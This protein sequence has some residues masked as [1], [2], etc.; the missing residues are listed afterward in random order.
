MPTLIN[1]IELS[2][3]ELKSIVLE[4][5]RR[6]PAD[7]QLSSILSEVGSIAIEQNIVQSPHSGVVSGASYALRDPDKNRVIDIIWDLIIERVLNMGRSGVGG[8]WPHLSVS[9]YGREVLSSPSPTPHD[10]SGYIGRLSREVPGIDP[11]ILVYIKESLRTYS[12]G[13]ILSST[14]TLGCASEKALLLLIE[15]LKNA[16]ADTSKK[17]RFEKKSE[18]TR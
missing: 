6:L 12:I 15:A 13:A 7:T 10:P 14:V 5:L 8:G 11:I 2:Y 3:E 18:G 4:A 16:I 9:S 17:E 1:A